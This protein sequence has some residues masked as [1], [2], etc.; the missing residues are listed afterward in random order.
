[1]T[2][3]NISPTLRKLRLK[4][5]LTIK[6]VA[7]LVGTSIPAL[8]RY[9]NG[10]DRFELSTLE[11][12]VTALGATLEIKIT[13]KPMGHYK[14]PTSKDIF[15]I[16]RP[17]FWDARATLKSIQDS[18]EWIIKRV[19]EYGDVEQVRA[20]L[21]FY[22]S[23]RVATVF[24]QHEHEFT[25]KSKAAWTQLFTRMEPKCTPKFSKKEPVPFLN[26]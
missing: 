5:G 21:A 4:R 20:T 10:W 9:E 12:I 14:K 26:R 16:L 22:S 17:L 24:W 11:R 19:L 8:H 2:L 13:P 1:M 7:G 25:P 15:K 18:T 3:Q 23:Q 6:Q